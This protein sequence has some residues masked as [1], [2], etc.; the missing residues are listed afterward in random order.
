VVSEY[1][2]TLSPCAPDLDIIFG[3]TITNSR[4]KGAILTPVSARCRVLFCHEKASRVEIDMKVKEE[5]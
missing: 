3:N 1:F 2:E 4:M 5:K